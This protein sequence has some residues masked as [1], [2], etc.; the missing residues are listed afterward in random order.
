MS[1]CCE[2]SFMKSSSFP[3]AGLF[4]GA[5]FHGGQFKTFQLPPITQHILHEAS[6]ASSA[7]LNHQT[8][9]ALRSDKLNFIGLP[10]LD[11]LLS[12]FSNEQFHI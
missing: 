12:L 4:S 2:S 3:A 1:E 11:L 6:N 9:T 8:K 7:C 10:I 5:V